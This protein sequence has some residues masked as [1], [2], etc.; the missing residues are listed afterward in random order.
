LLYSVVRFLPNYE[1]GQKPLW[2][3]LNQIWPQLVRIIFCY[4]TDEVALEV[5]MILLPSSL[6]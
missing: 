4:S 1:F 6:V 5:W 2:L 3:A